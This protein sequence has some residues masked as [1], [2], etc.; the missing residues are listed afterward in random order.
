MTTEWEKICDSTTDMTKGEYLEFYNYLSG[1]P[2]SHRKE[3][4]IGLR[5]V[6]LEIGDID[7]NSFDLREGYIWK[8]GVGKVSKMKSK[9]YREFLEWKR[10]NEVFEEFAE[11]SDAEI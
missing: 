4:A 10:Q 2:Y 5:P 3:I 6:W 1:V 9:K 8:W 7:P 11:A